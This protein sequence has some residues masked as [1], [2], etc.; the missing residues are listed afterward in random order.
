MADAI[1]MP[2]A[3]FSQVWLMVAAIVLCIALPYPL[4]LL[5]HTRKTAE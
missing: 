2:T 4:K 5:K 3:L 1:G